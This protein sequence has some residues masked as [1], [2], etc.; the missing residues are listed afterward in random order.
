MTKPWRQRL[1][2]DEIDLKMI[3]DL[4]AWSTC[5]VGEQ[6]QLYP[7]IVKMTNPQ[8]SESGPE[9]EVLTDLGVRIWTQVEHFNREAALETLSKIEDRVLEL[10][11]EVI[12]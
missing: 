8:A 7:D 9:D 10:K 12:S 2:E 4:G 6:A 11:R 1:I 3:H 5:A